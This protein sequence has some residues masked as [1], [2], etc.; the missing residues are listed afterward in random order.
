MGIYPRQMGVD[1]IDVCILSF[2][3]IIILI[4]DFL[5]FT[6]SSLGGRAFI[7]VGGIVKLYAI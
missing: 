6:T 7:F 2:I 4:S 1:L 3:E 5:H